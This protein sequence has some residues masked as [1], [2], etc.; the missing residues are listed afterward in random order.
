MLQIFDPVSR[1][2]QKYHGYGRTKTL[3]VS[4]QILVHFLDIVKSFN[5]VIDA[6]NGTKISSVC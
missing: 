3:C 6:C 5:S 4:I 2:T 1:P